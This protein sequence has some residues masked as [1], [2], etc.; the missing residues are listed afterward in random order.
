VKIK[1]RIAIM[2]SCFSICHAFIIGHIFMRLKTAN[3]TIHERVARGRWYK[4]GVR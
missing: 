3:I 4:S 1:V 2:A